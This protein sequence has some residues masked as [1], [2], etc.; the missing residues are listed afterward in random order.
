VGLDHVTFFWCANHKSNDLP[1]VLTMNETICP[2]CGSGRLRRSRSRSP[3]ERFLKFFKTRVYRCRDCRWRGVL[4]KR[5]AISR[6][7]RLNPKISSLKTLLLILLAGLLVGAAVVY[8]VISSQQKEHQQH[9]IV[10][11]YSCGEFNQ[12]H[13]KSLCTNARKNT[14]FKKHIFLLDAVEKNYEKSL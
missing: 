1:S 11:N 12:Q 3:I 7:T 10:L 14:K 4:H 9:E 8:Y 6:R 2:N 5:S 13:F